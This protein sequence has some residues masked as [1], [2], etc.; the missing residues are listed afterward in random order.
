MGFF[1]DFKEDITEAVNGL[2]DAELENANDDEDE[3]LMVN[4]LDDPELAKMAEE[5]KKEAETSEN[6]SI[7]DKIN[8]E[9]EDNTNLE[10]EPV[11]QEE[12]VNAEPQNEEEIVADET[13]VITEGL[14]ITGN[15]DS[16]GSIDLFGAVEGDVSCRGKLTISGSVVGNAKASE[17]FANNAQVDGNMIAK[18]A[19]KIGQGT[20]VVG[21]VS[22][23]SAVIAGAVK[24]DIDVH[25]PVIVDSSAVIVGDIKSKSVQINN[26]ATIDGRCSQCYADVDMEKL[27]D[28]KTK[29]KK[30]K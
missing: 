7:S 13:A 1:K 25:G 20:V 3:D 18:G 19:I 24:G 23:T 15:L 8:A 16:I 22:A 12:T 29:N 4:T 30:N 26:G 14:T 10:S 9:L 2:A 27:F 5:L 17:I 11:Q 6:S 28:I 21:N